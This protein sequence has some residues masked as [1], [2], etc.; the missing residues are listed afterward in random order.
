M[1]ITN[2]DIMHISALRKD[3]DDMQSILEC[4]TSFVEISCQSPQVKIQIGDG[5]MRQKILSMLR[6]RLQYEKRELYGFLLEK[7]EAIKEEL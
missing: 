1:N 6:E 3:I 2:D 5:D 4:G 7:A